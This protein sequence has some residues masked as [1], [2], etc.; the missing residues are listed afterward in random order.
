MNKRNPDQQLLHRP[1]VATLVA[2]AKLVRTSE[3][4]EDVALPL[5]VGDLRRLAVGRLE[6]GDGRV[7]GGTVLELDDVGVGLGLA[8]ELLDGLQL[9]SGRTED[10]GD[11]KRKGGGDDGEELHS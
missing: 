9:R 4:V 5:A 7:L 1:K 10:G 6:R 11:E 3:A 8:D 2:T